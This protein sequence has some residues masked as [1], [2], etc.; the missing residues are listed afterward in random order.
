[1]DGDPESASR[2]NAFRSGAMLDEINE[3]MGWGPCGGDAQVVHLGHMRP[4][5]FEHQRM[6]LQNDEG[7]EIF[8]FLTTEPILLRSMKGKPM[9]SN[10]CLLLAIS[11]KLNVLRLLWEPWLLLVPQSDAMGRTIILEA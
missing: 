3:V 10:S 4:P 1:M 11:G 8:E 9:P 5:V 6:I 7:L 2:A